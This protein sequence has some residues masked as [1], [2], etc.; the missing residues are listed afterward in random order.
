[1]KATAYLTIEPVWRGNRLVGANIAR[2][3]KSRPRGGVP[4]AAVVHLTVDIPDRVFIP[5][6]ADALVTAQTGDVGQVKVVIEPYTQEP[7]DDA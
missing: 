7:D 2:M 4:G 1:M 3:T 5:F 6:E